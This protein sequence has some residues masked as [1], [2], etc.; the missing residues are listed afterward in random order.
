VTTLDSTLPRAPSDPDG[1]APP[2]PGPPHRGEPESALGPLRPVVE[3]WPLVLAVVLLCIGGAVY[4]GMARSPT[5]R[6]ETQINIGRTDV[7]VQALPGYVAGAATLANSYSRVVQSDEIVDRVASA[8]DRPRASVAKDLTATPI[9]ENPIL[10]I[11]GEGESPEAAVRLTA[12]ATSELERY[13]SRTD[14]S[15]ASFET[16]LREFREQSRRAADLRRRLDRLQESVTATGAS[17]A[18]ASEEEDLRVEY[19]TAK[20]RADALGQMYRDRQAELASTAGIE[21]ISRPAP[22]GDDRRSVLQR[23]IAVGLVGGVVIGSA[24]AMLLGPRRRRRPAT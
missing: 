3:R 18:S 14:A 19:E 17:T 16:A 20:L 8:L 6:A 7:R 13:V 1:G 9:P 21:V 15:T 24:L 5:Y 12:T 2:G 23:L 4:A 22:S 11:I 10:R